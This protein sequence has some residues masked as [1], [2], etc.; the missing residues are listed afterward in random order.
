METQFAFCSACDV[1]VPIAVLPGPVH[2]GQAN[3][4][5][6]GEVVCL[7][8][9]EQCNG[10][11]C[12]MFGLPRMLMGVRLARSGL[13]PDGGWKTL[14]AYCEGCGHVSTQQVLDRQHA[15]CT[16]CS[17]VNRYV[18]LKLDEDT[19]VAAG[20]AEADRQLPLG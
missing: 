12:P 4:G 7:H 10:S 20:S 17:S 13:V 15:H 6:P 5:D 1:Q 18:I 14:E 8:F 2:G 3:L 11:F 16:E 9:G 19:F